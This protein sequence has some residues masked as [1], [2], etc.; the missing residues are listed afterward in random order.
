MKWALCLSRT[1][2]FAPFQVWYTRRDFAGRHPDLVRAFNAATIRGWE[3]YL[4]TDPSAVHAEILRRNP[5]TSEALLNY[6]RTQLIERKL[7]TGETGSPIG[8][9]DPTR[10]ARQIEQIDRDR[11]SDAAGE[12]RRSFRP[13]P[14]FSPK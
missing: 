3:D 13:G 5:R 12:S 7:V 10:L 14:Y 1:S 9:L 11:Y 4:T 8:S 6:S 2:G